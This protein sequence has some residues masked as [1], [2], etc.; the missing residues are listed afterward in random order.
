MKAD[1]TLL[2]SATAIVIAITFLSGLACQRQQ[3]VSLRT[4]LLEM[5]DRDAL[6]QA[7]SPFYRLMQFSSYDR[8]TV[9]QDSSGWFANDDYTRFTSV[10]TSA[11]R[12]EFVLFD[13]EGPGAVV[14]WWMTFAG[15]GGHEG[16]IRIYIDNNPVPV[17]ES[18][19][20]PLL[21][22][23]LLAGAP[24]SSSVSSE[25]EEL[26]RGHNLYI[27][28]PY[29][30]SCRITYEC[31]AISI[32]PERRTPSIYYNINYRKY[33]EGTRVVSF[34]MEELGHSGDLIAETCKILL[35][36]PAGDAGNAIRRVSAVLSPGDT[37]E[38][39]YDG[40]NESVRL[41]SVR[42]QARNQEQAMRSVVLK[43]T[44]DGI[45][46]IW[47]PVGEFF[48][49]GYMRTNFRTFFTK[50]DSTGYFESYWVMPFKRSSAIA[51]VNYGRRE[52]NVELTAHYGP[53]EWNSRTM[54][55]GSS[56]HEYH[57]IMA[58][59]AVVTG[60]TGKHTDLN[61][62]DMQGDGLYVGDA[63]TVFNTVDAWWGEGDE[64]IF[65]DGEEFPSSIGTGTEDY[66]GY[67]WC[68]PEPFE[69]PFIA[70]PSGNGN[71]H[72][73]QTINMRFRS[74]DAIPFKERIS[75]NIELW[76]WVPAI[77]NYSLTT[78]YYFRGPLVTNNA[79]RPESV[80]NRVPRSKE[81]IMPLP[82][83]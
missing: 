59:G 2:K 64:K 11:G 76:H 54:Y 43:A 69:H 47:A 66:Y 16:I 34:S 7:P 67:A 44:F 21:S 73:G 33:T 51:L 62:I 10:D 78:W 1:T 74:L 61:F 8:K 55:F 3:V 82:E 9:A 83:R 52:V 40:R 65:V 48:G 63:V 13:K 50:A 71:F 14:R 29:R 60:G 68:R 31:D 37:M 57:N 80:M 56:W 35:E 18:A 15:E 23:H 39:G 24:L 30:T 17:I 77:M 58:A 19:P 81:D 6:T 46:T 49:S 45:E 27:P 12:R 38:L 70:Q 22:G 79:A 53:K 4:L 25:T 26:R 28:I 75:S 20:I 42:L 5:T 32:G 72:P 36:L 41:L